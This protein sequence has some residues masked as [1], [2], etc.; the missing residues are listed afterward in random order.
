MLNKLRHSK[1]ALNVI[2]MMG[3]VGEWTWNV[4]LVFSSANLDHAVIDM[5]S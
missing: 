5:S 1:I 3:D 4:C 2:K